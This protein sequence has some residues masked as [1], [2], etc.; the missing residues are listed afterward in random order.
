[1]KHANFKHCGKVYSVKRH[2]K[3]VCFNTSKILSVTNVSYNYLFTLS[4]G[5]ILTPNQLYNLVNG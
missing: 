5:V 3:I 4:S 2:D 1:M